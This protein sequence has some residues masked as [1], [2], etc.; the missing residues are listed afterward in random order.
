MST[1]INVAIDNQSVLD[2]VVSCD[3]KMQ[4]SSYCFTVDLQLKSDRF[5]GLC[6]PTNNWGELRIKAI[7]GDTTYQFLIE[8]RD[9][10]TSQSGL[11]FSV[12]GRSRQAV[13]AT[14]F[15]KTVS[16]TDETSNPW[17]TGNTT[18]SEIVAYVIANYCDSPPAV[19]WNVV[20]FVVYEDS[21]SVNN[22]A[23]IDIISSLADV[24]G[25][26]LVAG[27]D[28]SLSIETYSVAE[29][30]AVE[31]YDDFDD[32]TQLNESIDVPSGYNAITV[33]GYDNSGGGGGGGGSVQASLA[34]SRQGTGD[35]YP[36]RNHVVRL[37][38]YHS[39]LASV[40]K[41]FLNGRCAAKSSGTEEIT[42]DVRLIFGKGNTSLPNTAGVTEV[43]GSESKPFE[44]RS[45]TYSTSYTDY[46]ISADAV[47][48]YEVMFY[49]SDKSAT[50]FYT[51]SVVA[52]PGRNNCSLPEYTTAA[53]CIAAGGTWTIGLVDPWDRCGAMK[54][55]KV[56][57]ATVVPGSLVTLRLYGIKGP[58]QAKWS[59]GNLDRVKSDWRKITDEA[60][61]IT[62]G[63]GNTAYPIDNR[64]AS[65]D[66]EYGFN[67]RGASM[68]PSYAY[69]AT[70]LIVNL[71]KN[72]PEY[73]SI[74]V[75]V[76]YYT[77]FVDYTFTVP[78]TWVSTIVTAWFAFSNCDTLEAN[79]TVDLDGEGDGSTRD[80]TI[81]ITDYAT[82]VDLETVSVVVD[83]S[84]KGNT[85]ADGNLSIA[86]VAVGDHTLRLTKSGYLDSD[87][88]DLANDT[89]TVS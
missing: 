3:I 73:Y 17:Q 41:Y 38:R 25:A 85:D 6:D 10:E 81:N 24:V 20:D 55:E 29:E 64:P 56:S 43:T 67:H 70:Q 68:L 23:P 21:F 65:P 36:G 18:A 42:E 39:T 22:Q 33:F 37:Y 50:A 53:E 27:I 51:F 19:T 69:G 84:W 40:Q 9:T 14:P 13:L 60:V 58:S 5:W 45:V 78:T 12:W 34:T 44:L 61:T 71:F 86:N 16:D 80:I 28:G 26:E 35:I 49:F 88:D 30:S 72:D 11:G 83:G 31:S 57:P 1:L 66:V 79:I 82:K 32:I 76:T 8:E 54:L 74:P 48:D 77:M 7:I 63:E 87:L 46:N 52:A 59:S 89:F 15:S 4:E 2:D 75:K 47:G 62:D